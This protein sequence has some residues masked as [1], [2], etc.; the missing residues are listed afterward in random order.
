MQV[1]HTVRC[2]LIIAHPGCC[3]FRS[4]ATLLGNYWRGT[5]YYDVLL[6]YYYVNIIPGT[7]KPK[8]LSLFVTTYS[9]IIIIY[10]RYIFFPS[11]SPGQPL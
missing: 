1:V 11:L 9:S 7:F 5:L 10:L 8:G 3:T 6:L 4:C 2:L